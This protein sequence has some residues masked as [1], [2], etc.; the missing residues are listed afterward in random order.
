MAGGGTV[1]RRH[2]AT[3]VS[4]S[5]GSPCHERHLDRLVPPGLLPW[6]GE[7]TVEEAGDRI[8]GEV[9]EDGVDDKLVGSGR[10]GRP[11]DEAPGSLFGADLRAADD[12]SAVRSDHPEAPVEQA[13][14][15]RPVESHLERLE[16]ATGRNA[17]D[18]VSRVHVAT[19]I[20]TD[21]VPPLG[22]GSKRGPRGIAEALAD[23]Q[24]K[25]R[26]LPQRVAGL[27]VRDQPPFDAGGVQEERETA[28]VP[29]PQL[30]VAR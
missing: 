12:A 11:R 24:P 14:V 5:D 18:P 3:R 30:G 4:Q 25:R 6:F 10:P 19:L 7:V 15:E 22:P 23:D 9:F 27:A 21:P 26:A 2:S 17:Q 28:P 29:V 13:M 8:P 16:G 1:I 20:L